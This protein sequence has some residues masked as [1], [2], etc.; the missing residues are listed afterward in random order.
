MLFQ[1]EALLKQGQQ[2]QLKNTFNTWVP[3]GMNANV[4]AM[5]VRYI[6]QVLYFLL[7]VGSLGS[8]KEHGMWNRHKEKN[9]TFLLVN[10]SNKSC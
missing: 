8:T 10:A 3:P 5:L 2:T 7:P 9:G 1:P 4:L 6:I